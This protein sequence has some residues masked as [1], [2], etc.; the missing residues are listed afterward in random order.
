[1]NPDKVKKVFSLT[2]EERYDYFIRKVADFE[3]VWLIK[4]GDS[5]LTLADESEAN[6]VPVFPEQGFAEL[7]LI[8]EWESYSVVKTDVYGFLEWLDQLQKEGTKI[9]C[10]PKDDWMAVVV[11]AD[12]MKEDLLEELK[13]YE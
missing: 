11:S 5:I 13:Q 12:E 9:A 2:S 3:K 6:S 4:D 1:M 8:G 7:L 10:F